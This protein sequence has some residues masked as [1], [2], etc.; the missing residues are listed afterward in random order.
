MVKKSALYFC[1][2]FIFA[3]HNV[4]LAQ[5][6]DTLYQRART[7]FRNAPLDTTYTKFSIAKTCY[8]HN[9]G[10]EK[11]GNCDMAISSIL[12]AQ[13]K[14]EQI[15]ELLLPT[16]DTLS[17]YSRKIKNYNVL[18]AQIH[19]NIAAGYIELRDYDEAIYY[20]NKVLSSTE[21]VTKKISTYN[22]MG[23]IFEDKL[24]YERSILYYK[25]VLDI[26]E[27]TF[28][29]EN[30][31][32]TKAGTF[33]NLAKAYRHNGDYEEALRNFEIGLNIVQE[34]EVR[35]DRQK[36]DKESLLAMYYVNIG[37][38]Y[39]DWEKYDK[40]LSVLNRLHEVKLPF[41]NVDT[42]PHAVMGYAYLGKKDYTKAVNSFN[43]AM[44]VRNKLHPNIKHIDKSTVYLS[45]GEVYRE[46]KQW[47]RALDNFQQ[48][49]IQAA[50]TFNDTSWSSNPSV[51]GVHH[52]RTLLRIL[53]FKAKTLYEYYQTTQNKTDLDAALNTY[54]TAV[55]L[56]DK[57]RIEQQH[58]ESAFSLLRT[59]RPIYE[60]AIEAAYTANQPELVYQLMEKSKAVILLTALRDAGAKIATGIPDSLLDKEKDLKVSISYNRKQLSDAQT[61][62]NQGKIKKY[63]SILFEK[64]EQLQKLLSQL[65]AD[66]PEYYAIKY[67][68]DVADI[69]EF[70]NELKAE[71]STAIE[72]FMGDSTLYA[73]VINDENIALHQ[74]K[75]GANFESALSDFLLTTSNPPT[76]KGNFI[77]YTN[78]A[79]FLYQNLLKPILPPTENILIIPDGRL[80]YLSFDALIQH[81]LTDEYDEPRYDTL[82]YLVHQYNINYAYS[83]SVL[84]EKNSRKSTPKLKPFAGFAPEFSSGEFTP[85]LSN[86]E[87]VSRSKLSKLVYNQQEVETIQ[88]IMGG[89][90]Y[91]DE[92]ATTQH[93]FD[94]ADEYRIVHFA[95]HVVADDT[96]QNTGHKIYLQDSTLLAD[97]IYNSSLNADLVVLSACETNQGELI[98]GEGVMSLARAFRYTGCPSLT[99]SLWSV[100][101]KS[102]ADIMIDFY[103]NLHAGQAQDQALTNSKRNYLEQIQTQA[104]APPFYWASFVHVGDTSEISMSGD[105]RFLWFWVALGLLIMLGLWKRGFSSKTI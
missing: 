34:L 103:K 55:E 86:N 91:L 24:D 40:T 31:T 15:P 71:K 33:S 12:F 36:L 2:F 14:Y 72:Y 9:Q 102:T 85:K 18:L 88:Q 47:Q 16:I 95:T 3:F 58:D 51:K 29:I 60:G 104:E 97:H 100:D 44:Q 87:I 62:D 99:A 63:N 54:Q 25:K 45:L 46:K 78:A 68:T 37:A 20:S 8:L 84:L 32:L 53:E 26:L 30:R 7:T 82:S 38:F 42:S 80:N 50:P 66:Y 1:F 49:L 89:S 101:D 83:A 23:V 28:S 52:V 21:D 13:G 96:I 5:D 65:E 67:N 41:L 76:K 57:I 22:N 105:N 17:K 75:K 93:F 90:A 73:C 39:N 35:D 77:T 70:K 27:D 74:F 81:P 43:E 59:A 92:A 19:T 48:A 64:R 6:C 61:A 94:H 10:W 79:T 4:G 98:E 11:F 56:V 69:D